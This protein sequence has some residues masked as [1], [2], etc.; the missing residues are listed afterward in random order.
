MK[1]VLSLLFMTSSVF[2]MQLD[3]VNFENKVNRFQEKLLKH[4]DNISKVHIKPSSVFA[5]NQLGS[6]ELYHDKKGFSVRQDDKKYKIQKCFTDPMVRNITKK[7]LNAFLKG[8]YFS[9]NQMNDGEFSLKAK[10]RIVG[11][12]PILGTIAYW[13]TK[14]VCY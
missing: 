8:G 7:Q 1:R 11:G 13:I 14:S 9:L 4:T 6:V 3:L 2:S 10:G 5:P 12:G